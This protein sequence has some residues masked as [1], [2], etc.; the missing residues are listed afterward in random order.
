MEKSLK[1]YHSYIINKLKKINDIITQNNGGKISDI[2][3]LS[4]FE[5]YVYKIE[6]AIHYL[7]ENRRYSQIYGYKVYRRPEDTS[8]ITII[9]SHL[10]FPK[11]KSELLDNKTFV[12]N[13]HRLLELIIYLFGYTTQNMGDFVHYIKKL[14][15]GFTRTDYL[16]IDCDNSINPVY[17]CGRAL[18]RVQLYP[19]AFLLFNTTADGLVDDTVLNIYNKYSNKFRTQEEKVPVLEDEKE[20]TPTEYK[21]NPREKSIWTLPQKNSDISDISVYRN[22][23]GVKLDIKYKGKRYSFIFGEEIGFSKYS[24]NG[25]EFDKS[26]DNPYPPETTPYSV[27]ARFFLDFFSDVDKIPKGVDINRLEILTG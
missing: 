23:K 6:K 20:Y 5:M 24:V 26:Y 15:D 4:Q 16:L 2:D 19:S 21:S 7:Q 14:V 13:L 12:S 25:I 11:V 1:D 22:G 27:N 3:F 10:N 17:S 9:L 18:M 8:D